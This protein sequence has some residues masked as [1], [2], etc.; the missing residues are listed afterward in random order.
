MRL[1]ASAIVFFCLHNAAQAD[2]FST[3]NEQRNSGGDYFS[4]LSENTTGSSY[5]SNSHSQATT[6][7]GY[8]SNTNSRSAASNDYFGEAPS[9][10]SSETTFQTILLIP[11][12]ELEST[13][14]S[15]ISFLK[16]KNIQDAENMTE[17][18]L[19]N[20][21]QQIAK[22]QNFKDPETLTC[23]ARGLLFYSY[24]PSFTHQASAM[25]KM[26]EV[27]LK[28]VM[29]T[30]GDEAA[31]HK[32]LA[33]RINNAFFSDERIN[34]EIELATELME[35]GYIL[36]ATDLLNHAGYKSDFENPLLHIKLTTCYNSLASASINSEDKASYQYAANYHSRQAT[37]NRQSTERFQNAESDFSDFSTETDNTI[38]SSMN[39]TL[40]SAMEKNRQGQYQEALTIL[41]SAVQSSDYKAA[42]PRYLLAQQYVVMSRQPEYSNLA[43]QYRSTALMHL[44]E[45]SS[46]GT[47]YDS[48]FTENPE[49]VSKSEELLEELEGYEGS[50]DVRTEY[51]QDVDRAVLQAV[52]LNESGK[53]TEALNLLKSLI[54]ETGG[55]S[56]KARYQLAQQ[57][58]NMSRKS[59]YASNAASYLQQAWHHLNEAVKIESEH[60][61][62][63]PENT[64]WGKNARDFK[65]RVLAMDT[66]D[67]N[68]SGDFLFQQNT[69]EDNT[70]EKPCGGSITSP[71]G[72]RIHPIYHTEKMHTGI[73]IGAG[74]GTPLKAMYHGRVVRVGT[75]SGYGNTVSILY[76]NG[77][78]SLYAHMKD[79]NGD[80]GVT[81]EGMRVTK[82]QTIGHVNTTGLSTG[83]HLHLEIQN[84][85]TRIDPTP[86]LEE[87]VGKRLSVG[88]SL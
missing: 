54:E 10:T 76:D 2:Y 38:L 9:H 13:R 45:T 74:G 18:Q 79:Y 80:N 42:K 40:N 49:Y 41:Q 31:N 44:R 27:Y 68:E 12:A 34:K 83:N 20:K 75:R 14:E 67:V 46:L 82:G 7:S 69:T 33:S 85:G 28:A 52:S 78:E 6:S 84:N 4:G 16:S 23:F 81:T 5:F 36:A 3:N 70:M 63:Y 65:D 43:Y 87:I 86:T 60:L 71:Y 58:V 73:D 61:D 72:M 77:K 24:H 35:K 11:R 8:F 62:K 29:T 47:Q 59:Q 56:A 51:E 30:D 39:Q 64:F 48:V 66:V 37:E 22:E 55:K 1:M 88:T 32:E 21:I 53:Y 26:A 17:E 19:L 57:Y 15:L 25:I 50:F